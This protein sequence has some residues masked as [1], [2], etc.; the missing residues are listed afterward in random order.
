[1]WHG[2]PE[3]GDRQSAALHAAR[4]YLPLWGAVVV[5]IDERKRRTALEC[6]ALAVVDGQDPQAITEIARAA[7]GP[8]RGVVDLVGSPE[9]AALGFDLPGSSGSCGCA[10]AWS[11]RQPA[12]PGIT[13]TGG[14]APPAKPGGTAP[15][16]RRREARRED[17][18][19]RAEPSAVYLAAAKSQSCVCSP[20]V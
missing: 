12:W 2:W 14:I 3:G 4:L 7:Q 6:G 19:R 1:M 20:S 17:S 16:S 8:V 18:T 11:C 15:V 9:T 5:D 10:A 13:G